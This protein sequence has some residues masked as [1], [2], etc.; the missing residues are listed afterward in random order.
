VDCSGATAAR[1]VAVQGTRRWGRCVLVGEGNRLEVAASADLIHRQVTVAGSWVTSVGHMED[2][3][4]HLARW[5]LHPDVT[6]TDRFGLADAADAYA[7]ADTGERG[8]V[9]LVMEG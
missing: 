9:A 3:V 5:D 7:V 6:V 1:T 8:K 2:L 4:A